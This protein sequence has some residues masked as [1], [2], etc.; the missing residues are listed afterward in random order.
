LVLIPNSRSG[1]SELISDLAG[2]SLRNIQKHL[3]LQEVD[4]S[5]PSFEIQTTTKPVDSLKKVPIVIATKTLSSVHRPTLKAQR[6]S[7]AKSASIF[8]WNSEREKL[9]RRAS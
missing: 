2:Y 4:V 9:F 3:K 8:E 1:L 6:V 5:L 7:E